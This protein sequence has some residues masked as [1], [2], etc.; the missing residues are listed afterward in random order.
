MQKKKLLK[1]NKLFFEGVIMVHRK[2]APF[3]AEHKHALLFAGGIATA[4]IGAKII[5]SQTTKELATKGMAGV[6][7]AKRDAEEAFQD[8]KENAEDI[9]FDA[10]A[11]NQQEIYVEKK[12]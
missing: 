3:V 2:I 8:M 9:V 4:I 10:S 5:K 7:S 6:I 1:K 11:E 12:E